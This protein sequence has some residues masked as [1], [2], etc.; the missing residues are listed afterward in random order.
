MNDNGMPSDVWAIPAVG[1]A[2]ETENGPK[3]RIEVQLIKAGSIT[4]GDGGYRFTA[5]Y[6]TPGILDALDTMRA[7]GTSI[8]TIEPG[9]ACDD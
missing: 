8:I 9:T 1:D 2:V 6:W 4:S 7:Y 3:I 5:D